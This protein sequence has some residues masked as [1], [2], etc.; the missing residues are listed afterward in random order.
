MR[1]FVSKYIQIVLK[2]LLSLLLLVNFAFAGESHRD[3]RPEAHSILNDVVTKVKPPKG[4][5]SD[6]STEGCPKIEKSKWAELFLSKKKIVQKYIFKRKCDIEGDLILTL[7]D[8]P[9]DL[10]TRNTGQ[11]HR[12]K[13]LV[14]IELDPELLE[15]SIF[16]TLTAKNGALINSEAFTLLTFKSKYNLTL[17][18]AGEIKDNKGGSVSVQSVNGQP[19]Q[20]SENLLFK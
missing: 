6:F 15:N 10:R 19:L 9:I 12:I 3:L 20:Y 17:D 11:V 8:S 1:C 13:A 18:L 7:D 5:E 14:S 2:G 4:V 16:V